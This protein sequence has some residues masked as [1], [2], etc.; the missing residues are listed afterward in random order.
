MEKILRNLYLLW[1][2]NSHLSREIAPMSDLRIIPYP[3]KRIPRIVEV[4]V[5]PLS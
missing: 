5:Y 2:K 4:Q 1:K 3:D